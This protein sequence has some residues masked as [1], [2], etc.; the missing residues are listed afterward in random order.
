MKRG[1]A[2]ATGAQLPLPFSALRS[3]IEKPVQ[4]MICIVRGF[5]VIFQPVI[6]HGRAGPE[7]GV[8]ESVG[9]AGID[10][11]FNR[12]PGAAP[13]PN[14]VGA[15]CRRRPIVERAYEDERGVSPA[16]PLPID[17][18]DRPARKTRAP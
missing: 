9:R 17:M 15:V 10:D 12:R 11:Q 13:A 2:D 14:L 16:A 3:A 5:A 6:E 1:A 8:I 7:V 18:E 4:A